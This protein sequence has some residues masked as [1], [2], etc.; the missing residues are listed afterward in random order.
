MYCTTATA[1]GLT[2]GGSSTVHIYTQ[3]IHRTTQSTQ[4]QYIEQHNSLIRKSAGRAPSLRVLPWHLPYN[5]GKSTEKNSKSTEKLFFNRYRK[6]IE[7]SHFVKIRPLGAELF[8]ADRQTDRQTD[9]HDAANSRFSQFCQRA[10]KAFSRFHDLV[11]VQSLLNSIRLH[12]IQ[13]RHKDEP[14]FAYSVWLNPLNAELTLNPLKPEWNPICY[15]LALLRA[16]HFLHV[17]RIRVKLL[18]FSLLMS[19][20]YG[21]PILDVSRSHTTTQHSG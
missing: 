19:Y 14:T 5:W 3:T 21:A 2:P 12:S 10:K 11:H 18:T 4:T 17:S 16:H 15:L 9:R 6:N 8:H 13:L 7:I 1:I 20:I